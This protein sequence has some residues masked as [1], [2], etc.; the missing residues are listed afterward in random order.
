MAELEI[1]KGFLYLALA[2]GFLWG[3]WSKIEIRTG[4]MFIVW[5]LFLGSKWIH[6]HGQAIN[7]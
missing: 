3:G 6:I 1:L 7:S 5:I 4:G 2:G